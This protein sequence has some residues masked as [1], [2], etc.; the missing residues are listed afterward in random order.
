[1]NGKTWIGLLA[2][3]AVV[4]AGGYLFTQSGGQPVESAAVRATPIREFVEERGKTRLP[5]TYSITMP[6]AGRIESLE[7]LAEG[8]AVKKEQIVAR[9]VP[10]DLE[11][12]LAAMTAA[13]E[14]MDASIQENDDLTVENVSLQ[15]TYEMV[16]SMETTV[17][18]AKNRLESGKAKYEFAKKN[19]ERVQSLWEKKTKT[20]EDLDEARLQAIQSNVDYRQDQL[21]LASL[22]A[23]LVATKLMPVAL[24][25]YMTRKTEKT[26]DVLRKQLDEAVVQW[27]EAERDRQRG[28]MTSPIDGV[29]LERPIVDEQHIP[30]GTLLLKLGNLEDLELEMDVLSQDVVRVKPGQ[31]VEIFGPAI[32]PI[33]AVGVVTRIYPAGFTKVSSLGVEQQRVKVIVGFAEGELP[34]LLAQRALGVDYR[35]RGRIITAEKESALTIP[36]SALFRGADNHW[37]VFAI[38]DGVA[39][40]KKVQIGLI[41][42]EAAEVLAGL[43]NGEEVILAPETNLVEGARV[44]STAKNLESGTTLG[45]QE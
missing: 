7:Q 19:L 10:R 4:L 37:Q 26:S 21:V 43:A 23:M 20:D 45:G 2:I 9:V 5:R 3:A 42:D 29:V 44:S 33:P 41:N 34:R 12:K 22:E 16:R 36:R 15:Q 35:V 25:A 40:L 30:A 27:R 31:R 1:M 28:T 38:A 17:D 11:L 39:K 24:Q 8:T 13:K 18:A 6:F 14:R 32:G